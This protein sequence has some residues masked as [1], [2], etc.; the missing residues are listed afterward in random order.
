[1]G[2]RLSLSPDGS[3]LAFV[4]TDWEDEST[5][6]YLLP[7]GSGPVRERLR[8]AGIPTVYTVGGTRVAWSRDSSFLLLGKSHGEPGVPIEFWYVPADGSSPQRLA[9]SL[10]APSLFGLSI[11]PDGRTLALSVGQPGSSEI[12]KL[13]GVESLGRRP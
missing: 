6:L 1:M 13:E 2:A 7:T 11:H 10:E 12:W 4:L 3:A 5:R 9:H 8:V